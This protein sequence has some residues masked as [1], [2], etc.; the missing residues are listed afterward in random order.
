MPTNRKVIRNKATLLT[1]SVEF[2][3]GLQVPECSGD[4]RIGDVTDNID[5]VMQKSMERSELQDGGNVF[6]V[7][8][9]ETVVILVRTWTAILRVIA[10]DSAHSEQLLV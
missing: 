4:G 7:I 3:V 10:V 8:D 2:G 9:H 1:D 6:D 5:C